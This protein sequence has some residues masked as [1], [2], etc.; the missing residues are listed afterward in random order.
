MQEAVR[1]LCT[2]GDRILVAGLAPFLPTYS[3]LIL[4]YSGETMSTAIH[5]RRFVALPSHVFARLLVWGNDLADG[6]R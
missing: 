2:A 6:G 5:F 1:C 4:H 3:D